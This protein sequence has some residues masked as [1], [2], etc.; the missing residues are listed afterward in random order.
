[1]TQRRYDDFGRKIAEVN[2]D[3]GAIL[4]R[5]D[6]AGHMI[7]KIDDSGGI[8][9]Y[10]YDHAGRLTGVGQDKTTDLV[11]YRYDGQRVV[12]VIA[13]PDGNA[14]HAAERTSYQYNAW[15][16]VTKEVRWLRRVDGAAQDDG[17]RFITLN[18]YDDVGRLVEQ[19]LPDGH[20]LRYRYTPADAVHKQVGGK[21]GQLNAIFFDDQPIVNEIEQSQAGQL[22]G[23]THGNGVRQEIKLD[24]RGRIEQLQAIAQAGSADRSWWQ[25]IQAWFNDAATEP[26]VLYRQS[27]RYDNAN[28]LT[29]LQYIRINP[30]TG[31]TR[32][33]T[34][35][36]YGYDEQDRLTELSAADGMLT[37]LRYD[38]GGNRI[39]EST[40]PASVSRTA[41]DTT[42]AQANAR[43][44]QYIPG[45]NRLLAITQADTSA[46]VTAPRSAR[47]AAELMRAVWFYHPTGVPL[48]QMRMENADANTGGTSSGSRRVVYSAARRPIA[49]YD[50]QNRLLA[51]Y[52]YNLQGERVAK[53]VYSYNDNAGLQSAALRKT[54]SEKGANSIT[55]Y[56]LYREQR[57][58]A[59]TD[60][61]G[62]ITAHYVYLNGKA[63]AK[64]VMTRNRGALHRAWTALVT[65]GGTIPR[66]SAD[67]GTSDA[68]IYAIHT[69]HLGTPQLV[70][71]ARQRAVWQ[72]R[73]DAFGKARI[74]YAAAI[75]AEGKEGKRFAMNLRLPGQIYDEETGLHY[76]YLRDY[77]PELGRYTTPDPLG[78][79]GGMNPYSYVSN[80]PLTSIDP[81]GLYESDI[82]YYMTF[83]LAVAAGINAEDARRLALGAQYVDDNPLTTPMPQGLSEAS[84]KNNH[85][86]LLHYHFVL[87][88]G[89]GAESMGT[90]ST[91]LGKLEKAAQTANNANNK[92]ACLQF[93]GEYLH[94]FEDTFS[95]R[96]PNNISFDPIKQVNVIKWL[97]IKY[98]EK[99]SLG[100][101]HGL[102]GHDPDYTYNHTGADAGKLWGEWTDKDGGTVNLFLPPKIVDWT[103]NE[104]RTLKMEAAV[105]KELLAYGDQ[106]KAKKWD[107]IAPY[108]AAFNAI[109]ENE[110][111]TGKN[112]PEKLK[113][114]SEAF[115]ALNIEGIDLNGAYKYDEAQAA[116]NRQEAIQGLD[117][118]DYDGVLLPK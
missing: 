21:P 102:Y 56:S 84:M 43:R 50:T 118:K 5:Y 99:E 100:L 106:T 67:P 22:T 82:H 25:R 65:L 69:N 24:G 101:G 98:P 111:S 66:D 3:R 49:V 89:L 13:T 2:P 57:L 93:L 32:S 115:A 117:S 81:L 92:N 109:H 20:R 96:D 86:A 105:F 12:D 14:D 41:L 17:L 16:S 64:I 103:V 79:A 71:D 1:V 51:R 91:Q 76:N 90:S 53:T 112:F 80:N 62:D 97:F 54:A 15:G 60:G 55:T 19:T 33:S 61:H 104:D 27:N 45:T 38:H 48:A 74:T 87:P 35:E 73:T 30:S 59:E 95:H 9:R 72:A 28:R 7:A 52:H 18:R 39:A 83:F 75:D 114:L 42:L 70:T 34:A 8:S 29:D 36:H 77:D 94:A 78:L 10:A 4:Y 26:K 116:S 6:A 11:R 85:D 40:Q 23:Y 46:I 108:L 88:G 107:E 47:E 68:A 44:Y 31:G 63:I 37:R 113:K 58:A 110:D